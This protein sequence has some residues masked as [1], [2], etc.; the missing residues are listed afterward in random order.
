MVGDPA[1]PVGFCPVVWAYAAMPNVSIAA[2]HELLTILLMLARELCKEVT[3]PFADR[4][5]TFYGGSFQ[6]PSARWVISNFPDRPQSIL[7]APLNPARAT[8]AGL[9]PRGLGCYGIFG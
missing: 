6:K 2:T 5:F 1:W 3:S 8:L 7:A 4:A 9:H